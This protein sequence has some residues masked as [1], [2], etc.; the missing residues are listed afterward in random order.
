[1][2]PWLQILEPQALPRPPKKE[3][4][5][6]GVKAGHKPCARCKLAKREIKSYCR[7]CHNHYTQIYM[8]KKYY[9]DK[10]ARQQA[11]L[12]EGGILA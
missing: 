1:M 8:K 12:N 5:Y 4:V 3:R 10:A 6:N 9:A 2:N 11:G 7:A